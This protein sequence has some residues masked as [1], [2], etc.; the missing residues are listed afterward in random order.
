[1]S[2]TIEAIYEQGLF[3]PLGPLSIPE[4]QRVRLH[5]EAYLP[6][7]PETLLQAWEAVYA[8]LSAEDIAEIEAVVLDRSRFMRGEV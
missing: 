1:M 6:P 4:H 2:Q 8:D 3:R 7:D 5:I